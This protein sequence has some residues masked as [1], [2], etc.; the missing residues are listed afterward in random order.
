MAAAHSSGVWW[1]Q[2]LN[3]GTCRWCRR[4]GAPTSGGHPEAHPE[5]CRARPGTAGGGV[6]DVPRLRH[7]GRPHSRPILSERGGGGVLRAGL[8]GRDGELK[9]LM[10]AV[11][12][13]FR[14]DSTAVVV[15]GEPGIG[16]T[17]LL[18]TLRTRV[19]ELG[20]LVLTGRASEFEQHPLGPFVDALD[21]HLH[22]LDETVLE[23]MSDEDRTRL[24]TL[25]PSLGIRVPAG[26]V[27]VGTPEH[28]VS[29]YAAIRR[30]LE[31]VSRERPLVLVLDDLH[32]ADRSS[33]ELFAFLLRRPGAARLLLVG[34]YR[35]RQVDAD[36]AADVARAVFDGVARYVEV[37]PLDVQRVGDLMGVTDRR[38]AEEL[39]RVSG[40]NPF[41]LL[42]LA[43]TGEHA[44]QLDDG[45]P[46]A[47]S[48]AILA[49][50]DRAGPA[51]SL[52]EGAAVVGDPF[53]LDLAG[54]V[55]GVDEQSAYELID[56]LVLRGI[57]ESGDVPRQFAFRHPL[58]R[59]AVYDA[60]PPGR[61]LA[62][63]ERCVA[64]LADLGAPVTDL[65][66]HLEHAARAGDQEAVDVLVEA[67]DQAA[68]RA[69]ASAVRWLGTALRLLP[70]T[71]DPSQRLRL[72]RRQP[73]LLAA[74]GEPEAALASAVEALELATDDA[75]R[76]DLALTSVAIEQ[77]LGRYADAHRRLVRTL[78]PLDRRSEPA[79]SVMVAMVLD[80][81]YNRDH[82]AVR[83]WT[84]AAASEAE[85][86]QKPVLS[87]AAHAGAAFAHALGG[88]TEAAEAHL[89]SALELLPLLTDA[90]L[91]RRLDVLGGMAGAELY[92]DRYDAC[93]EHGA[94]GLALALASG[95]MWAVPTLGPA[96]GTALWVAGR[97]E[98]SIRH[99][100]TMVEAAR[101]ARRPETTAW[102]LFNLAF[103]LAVAGRLEEASDR[104]RES[105]ELA[106]RRSNTGIEAWAGAVVA[107]IEVESGRPELALE[108]LYATCGGAQLTG[109][110]GGWR[111][112]AFDIAV[113][114]HVARGDVRRAEECAAGATAWA[115]VVGLPFAQSLARRAV[116]A[117]ALAGGDHARAAEAASAAATAADLVGAR[118][119]AARART[120]AGRAVEGTGDLE[121]AVA[122][123]TE[124]AATLDACGARR[125]RDE[126]ERELGRVG[127]RP[128]RRTSPGSGVAGLASLTAREREIADLVVDRLTNPEIAQRIFLS[129]KTVESHLRNIFRKVGVGSRTELARLVDARG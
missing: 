115:D 64:G 22:A 84:S 10:R 30:L 24:A 31:L 58:V 114:A 29:G 14:G 85:R 86:L 98:E 91:A 47:I 82:E 113:R 120:L 11:H 63:H 71:A 90:D 128:H 81:F 89:D 61:R 112:Y 74:L 108:T 43:G 51:R 18:S 7:G 12:E 62:L 19:D 9:A 65:A 28:R 3:R 2:S 122:L 56:Q 121:G 42:T 88:A 104:G 6:V 126:A 57:V 109:I 50:L 77:G 80:A 25:F 87:A 20:G 59:R 16:K 40:G 83:S 125:F 119:D 75:T 60:L 21:A 76:V 37:N 44:P 5:P 67:A 70:G 15:A 23:A 127:R 27:S 129:T 68:A 55:A 95:D 4:A 103:A 111:T 118:V 93:I 45:L 79:V 102:G 33:L 78:E 13:A 100:D 73:P 124:A 36:L 99:C 54:W 123:W 17:F 41:Y 107:F 116:A 69:P 117:C 97:V 96:Y 72:A 34:A 106:G 49:E 46:P 66:G 92:L 32:W 53:G 101:A 39:H 38:S 94:R 110:P 48:Q 35:P 8:V 1:W 26:G 105:L 52:A